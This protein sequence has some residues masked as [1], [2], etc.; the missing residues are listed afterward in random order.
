MRIIILNL[1]WLFNKLSST[2][3]LLIN[4]EYQLLI[5]Y[6]TYAPWIKDED[7][8]NIYNK[9][10]KISLVSIFQCWELLTLVEDTK[11]SREMLSKSA[12]TEELLQ[13][14]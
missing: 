14:L 11:K 9:V 2:I 8:Q 1:L 10:K 7:F 13:L 4:K 12:H 6:A 3:S 5:P